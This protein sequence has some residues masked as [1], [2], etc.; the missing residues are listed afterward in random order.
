VLEENEIEAARRKTIDQDDPWGKA[1]TTLLEETEPEEIHQAK[2]FKLTPSRATLII[3][4]ED[5]KRPIFR[6]IARQKL[7]EIARDLK[8]ASLLLEE[9]IIGHHTIIAPRTEHLYA[10]HEKRE[11]P[12]TNE[13]KI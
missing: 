10:T 1:I 7:V 2:V 4:L 6:N 9:Y 5:T 8:G 11:P 3:E 13:E 12:S